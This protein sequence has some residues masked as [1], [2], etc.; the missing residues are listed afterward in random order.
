ME[1]T[2]VQQPDTQKP[3]R[4]WF[5]F[6]L[7]ISLAIAVFI[8]FFDI[9][10]LNPSNI[11]WLMAGDLGQHFTGWHAFRY[12]QWHF[13]LALTKLLG[14]PQGVPIVFTDSNP[15]LAL[16]FKIIGHILPCLQKYNLR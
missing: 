6:V 2:T 10:I 14:W 13:P 3:S 8:I 7:I 1:E 4:Y 16:P 12:D 9:N 15:V 11:D 5:G